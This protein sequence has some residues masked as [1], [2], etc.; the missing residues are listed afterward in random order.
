M[1][2]IRID[3]LAKVN[4][5]LDVLGIRND[6]Y[7][8]MQMINHSIQL[9]DQLCF[10]TNENEVL[11]TSNAKDI[12]LG[13]SNFVLIAI[14]AIQ[15]K[16]NVNKGVTIHLDKH[17]PH[18][19][20]LGGGSSDA[21]AVL[22][23]LNELWNLKLKN[24]ELIEIGVKI[25]A[26]VPYCLTGGTALVE[27]IGEKITALKPINKFF[28]VVIK[29]KASSSTP[30]AFKALDE[31]GIKNRPKIQELING[32]EQNDEIRMSQ[33]I[34]NVFE[35]VLIAKYP[36]IEIIKNRLMENGAIF[37]LM[38]GS[39]TTVIGYYK[40]KKTA[41]IAQKKLVSKYKMC[42]LTETC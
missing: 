12:P 22:K 42:I 5:S 30:W 16:Y 15:K 39:G 19:A 40:D 8:E 41:K 7:H 11:F 36:E 6:G 17:I 34:G 31:F 13:E 26:D 20:G 9:K 23:G 28:L 27:G 38:T 33:A 14:R 10:K 24:A 2:E 21:A 29:P 35:D 1:D 25:G 32:L 18:E 4:L 3:A 37:A